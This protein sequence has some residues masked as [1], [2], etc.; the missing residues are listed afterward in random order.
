MPL[1]LDTKSDTERL[2]WLE[3]NHIVPRY[4]PEGET[5]AG[6]PV[7]RIELG[8]TTPDGK[9]EFVGAGDTWREAID[10]ARNRQKP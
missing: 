5:Y 7:G 8:T 2:D 9:W 6:F 3:S 1:R 4:F 10:A